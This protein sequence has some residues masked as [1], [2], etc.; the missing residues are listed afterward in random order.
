[1]SH[2][3]PAVRRYDDQ[4][5]RLFQHTHAHADMS[6]DAKQQLFACKW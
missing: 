2:I 1:M 4:T 3:Y 6:L 5:L